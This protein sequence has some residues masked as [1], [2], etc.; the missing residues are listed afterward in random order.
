LSAALA[1]QR[2]EIELTRVKALATMAERWDGKL[3]SNVI[4]S[5]NPFMGMFFGATGKN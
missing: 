3:P 5:D 2:I 1:K 4:P